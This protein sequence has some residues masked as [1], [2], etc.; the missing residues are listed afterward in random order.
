M[1]VVVKYPRDNVTYPAATAVI[2]VHS[3]DLSLLCTTGDC[4]GLHG[5]LVA[6]LHDMYR[7]RHGIS[8]SLSHTDT[9]PTLSDSI[10]AHFY[11]LFCVLCSCAVLK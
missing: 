2:V 9:L 6:F 10:T 5:D 11:V 1:C 3:T 7:S 4:Y 8:I